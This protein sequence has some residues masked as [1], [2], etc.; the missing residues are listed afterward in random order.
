MAL[1]GDGTKLCD[2]GT[3]DNY[4]AD[5]SVSSL[6]DNHPII[7][8]IINV[9]RKPYWGQTSVD[10]NYCLVSNSDDND[11]WV[12]QYTPAKAVTHVNVGAFPQRERIAV[13]PDAVVSNL[14]PPSPGVG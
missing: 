8:K 14:T 10:G 6:S 9:G 3:I 11:V 13:V 12:V 7:Q 4:V 1:S 2:V 5:V